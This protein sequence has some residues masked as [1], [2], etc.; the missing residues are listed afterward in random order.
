MF[1]Y[2]TINVLLSLTRKKISRLHTV[3]NPNRK[4]NARAGCHKGP[5][6]KSALDSH[7]GG[8]VAELASGHVGRTRAPRRSVGVVPA[9]S[10]DRTLGRDGPKHLA[11]RRRPRGPAMA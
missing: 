3:T 11:A 6:R 9:R 1:R 4:N 7:T 2:V 8:E 5:G 10:A